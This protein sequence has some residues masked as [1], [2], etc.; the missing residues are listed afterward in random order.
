MS[1]PQKPLPPDVAAELRK[2]AIAE[3]WLRGDLDFKRHSGQLLI[4]KTIKQAPGR[5]RFALCSRRFGKSV[6]RVLDAMETCIQISGARVVYLAPWAKNAAEIASDIMSMILEDCP[7][8]LRPEWK[9]QAHEFHF[10][11][12]GK[13]TS[14]LRLRG[15]NGETADNLRGGSANLIVLDEAGQMD[16]L[17][18]IVQDICLPMTMVCDGSIVLASTPPRTPSHDSAAIYEELAGLGSTIKLTL[19]DAPHI[20]YDR[21]VEYLVEAGERRERCDGI[22]SGE[23]EPETTTARR[24]YF[25]E[26]VTDSS[27]AVVPEF[28]AVARKEI[29]REHERPEYCTKIVSMD[30]GMKDRTG[31]LYGYYDFNEDLIVV[32]DESLLNRIDA[33]TSGIA[34]ELGQKE[35]DLWNT[36]KPRQRVSDVDL[37]LQAD[38]RKLGFAFVSTE[39]KNS[40]GAINAMRTLVKDRRIV[41][42]PKCVNLI[43]QLTN[44]IWNTKASDFARPDDEQ[45][46]D[47]HYDL[48]AALKYLIRSIDKR[49]NPFPERYYARGGRFGPALGTWTSP[50]ASGRKG[51]LNLHDDTPTGRRMSG[52][53]KP[54]PKR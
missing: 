29:V 43:R 31:I 47:G 13:A 33:E 36:E 1:L 46:I 51:K 23:L 54:K 44:C 3:L 2:Q 39:K 25:C 19:R 53:T 6:D 22:L 42:N 35:S 38:L 12:H 7:P 50:R 34:K 40:I 9:T 37:R 27:Q 16:D 10:K 20:P 8:H 11:R 15:V 21:K 17:R 26:F 30:P 32:E 14:I 52:R 49:T 18:R 4:K 45:A 41:I 48:V 28:D 24:E 5:K